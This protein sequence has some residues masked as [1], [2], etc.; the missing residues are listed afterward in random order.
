MALLGSFSASYMRAMPNRKRGSTVN[1]FL[2]RGREREL[3]TGERKGRR[4]HTRLRLRHLELC[5]GGQDADRHCTVRDKLSRLV[6]RGL[7]IGTVAQLHGAILRKV[8]EV[9][10]EKQRGEEEGKEDTN[11]EITLPKLRLPPPVFELSLGRDHRQRRRGVGREAI[12]LL[13]LQHITQEPCACCARHTR[14]NL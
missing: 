12:Q 8:R 2:T 1:L 5:W 9:E 6:E 7:K 11:L 10:K 14:D 13:L 4:G 3:S